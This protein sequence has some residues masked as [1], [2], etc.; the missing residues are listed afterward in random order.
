MDPFWNSLNGILNGSAAPVGV[1]PVIP[2]LAFGALCAAIGLLVVVIDLLFF[3]LRG[4]SILNLEHGRNTLPIAL[5]WTLGSGLIG[6]VGQYA[7]ILQST[8]LASLT[9]GIAWPKIFTQWLED[10]A[11]RQQDDEPE[12]VPLP[13]ED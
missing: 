9:V 12:Q 6:A 5:A 8:A 11:R 3:L 2:I 13:E 4:R 7:E 1:P 10:L